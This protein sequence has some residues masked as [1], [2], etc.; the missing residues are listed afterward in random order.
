MLLSLIVL[1]GGFEA[2]YALHAGAERIGRYLQTYYEGDAATPHWET[3]AMA[4]GPALPG[5]GIDPLFTVVFVSVAGLN[6]TALWRLFPTNPELILGG[7]FHLVFL[8]R[9]LRARRAA[10]RQRLV[11]LEHFRALR[12]R[13]AGD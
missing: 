2:I 11:E 7:L 13:D 8:V 4:I 6:L 9:V 1:V 10:A 5:G 3:A 12:T